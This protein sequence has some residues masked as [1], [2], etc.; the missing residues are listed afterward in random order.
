MPPD[1]RRFVLRVGRVPTEFFTGDRGPLGVALGKDVAVAPGGDTAPL[2][3]F[4][5]R[6]LRSRLALLQL[7]L[8]R[9]GR[10]EFLRLR[11][12]GLGGQPAPHVHRML[13]APPA[14]HAQLTPEGVA[15]G[16]TPEV[17]G[18]GG[19]ATDVAHGTESQDLGQ[20][21]GAAGR[22]RH[23]VPGP[24]R[25]PRGR[26]LRS[27]LKAPDLRSLH[28]RH[29]PPPQHGQATLA[30][31]GGCALELCPD[32]VHQEPRRQPQHRP[33][34]SQPPQHPAAPRL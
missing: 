5:P 4:C 1:T 25:R 29:P 33:G 13:L 30:T 20:D 10:E 32:G 26:A 9:V 8:A 22:L 31:P 3:G 7:L 28:R 21:V 27:G 16:P 6:R 34:P 24:Q 18:D 2:R 14:L 15:G 11:S 12:E 17:R 19:T 23:L